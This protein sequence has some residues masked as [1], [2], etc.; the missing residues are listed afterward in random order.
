ML[1]AAI[2]SVHAYIAIT[3]VAVGLVAIWASFLVWGRLSGQFDDLEEGKYRVFEDGVPPE[4]GQ[5][6]RRWPT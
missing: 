4:P 6:G 3:V 5:E 1:L 2:E